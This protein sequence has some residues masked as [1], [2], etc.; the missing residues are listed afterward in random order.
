MPDHFCLFGKKP[1]YG[2]LGRVN[3]A[4][5]LVYG[6]MPI[7]L[8]MEFH[9]D[10]VARVPSAKIVY[11]ANAN[12]GDCGRFD[13]LALLMWQLVIQKLA[14]GSLCDTPS[15]RNHAASDYESGY[16]IRAL[17]SGHAGQRQC[18]KNGPI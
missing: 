15:A 2:A 18:D 11:A 12:T 7:D 13:A 1:G 9:K 4:M 5:A 3:H 16:R 10:S 14:R 17:P 8:Q 6:N